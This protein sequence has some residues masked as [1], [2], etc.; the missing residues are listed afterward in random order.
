MEVTAYLEVVGN[1]LLTTGLRIG[2]ILILMLIALKVTR[3]ATNRIFRV[4]KRHKDEV[5]YQKRTQTLSSVIRHVLGITILIVALIAV[6]GELGIE[7]G[8]VIAAAGVVGLAVGFGA[9][10]LVK[11]VISG[12]FILLEDQIHVGDWVQ[13]AG[14]TGVVERINLKMTV[15][16]DLHGNVH[17]VPNGSIDVVTNLTR[18]YSRA[19]LDI[20]VAYRED[21]DEVMEVMRQVDE[22]L[23]NDQNFK[24]DI[25]EPM[26]VFGLNEFGD[27]ALVIRGRIKTKA[28]KQWGIGR[29]YRRR[30]KRAFD[31]RNIEIPFP[32]TTIYMGEGKKGEAPPLHVSVEQDGEVP[33]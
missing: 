30:L 18:E 25:L 23:R 29:E 24:D 22:E 12:F 3:V 33:S 14:Q 1:W 4:I 13:I 15:L 10:S 27:S 31:E 9:Q 8:P 16:R 20:G 28:A 2:V 17:F 5:D 7:I 26:E 6:L 11:D 19:V 21:V 32:H